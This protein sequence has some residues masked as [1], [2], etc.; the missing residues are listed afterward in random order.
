MASLKALYQRFKAWQREP[1]KYEEIAGETH[2]CCNC[3][4]E[5]AG[6]YCPRCGQKER[7]G[8]ITWKTVRSGLM[9]LFGLGGRSLPYSVWQL[10]W[11]PGYFISDYINGKWQLSF[12]PVKML[13]IVTFLV[14]FIGQFLFPEYWSE[15]I[16]DQPATVTSTGVEYYVDSAINWLS[17]HPE[18]GIL[19][20]FSILIL[21]TWFVFKHAPR[22]PRH[23]LPQGFFIQVFMTTQYFIWNFVLS[24]VLAWTGLNVQQAWAVSV[25][26]LP[27]MV[28]LDYKQLFGYGLRGTLWRL[29]AI[30]VIIA[31]SLLMIVVISVALDKP[32]GFLV[33]H[34][35]RPILIFMTFATGLG[36]LLSLT[37]AINRKS[38][39]ERGVWRSMLLPLLFFMLMVLCLIVLEM[40]RPG[41][42][43]KVLVS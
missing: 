20:I 10:L 37:D 27:L 13:V 33:E 2:C 1:C 17:A 11:R 19:F 36:T 9:D 8:R 6:A 43:F 16:E 3:G 5:Y 35:F 21:P 29:A 4:Q 22:N 31:L 32:D 25:C 34:H 38:W 23:T 42:F 12:P 39:R 26:F 14:F 40:Q 41:A 7:A 30:V 15:V 28:L 18:W 24:L